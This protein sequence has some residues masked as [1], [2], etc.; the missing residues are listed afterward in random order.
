MCSSTGSISPWASSGSRARISSMEPLRSANSTVSCLRSPPD[1]PGA[2]RALSAR[3]LAVGVTG[4]AALGGGG[5]AVG[6]GGGAGGGRGGGGRGAGRGGGGGGPAGVTELAA[7]VEPGAAG[8]AERG[9]GPAALPAESRPVAVL[10]LAA[11][12]VHDGL[13]SGEPGGL[14]PGPA[15]TGV[16]NARRPLP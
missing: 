9:G 1:A 14:G 4:E 8:G 2:G 6:G 11:G 5:G 10:G 15:A 12:A 7:G 3:R 13:E 16:R